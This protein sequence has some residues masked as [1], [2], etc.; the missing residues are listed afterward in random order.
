MILML[1]IGVTSLIFVITGN[2]TSEIE[3][4]VEWNFSLLVNLYFA[5]MILIWKDYRHVFA[6][7]TEKN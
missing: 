4:V 6:I 2:N 3:N 5:G 1:I 7:R